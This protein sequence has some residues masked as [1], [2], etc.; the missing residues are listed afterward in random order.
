MKTKKRK[1][2][3]FISFF[4]CITLFLVGAFVFYN[5]KYPLKF[6]Q[7]INYYSNVFNL[8]PSLVASIINEESSF[9]CNCVS[10]SGAIGLM[11]IIPNTARY[12]AEEILKEEYIEEKLF[13][14]ETNIKYGCCYLNYLSKKFENTQEVLCAYNA[15][16]T[17]VN[18]WLNNKKYSENGKLL[19]KIPYSETNIYIN[20]ILKGKKYYMGRI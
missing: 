10:N 14:P 7:F 9:K 13:L 18:K 16:E 1:I 5:I 4:I 17:I 15:G 8:E 19:N 11:Q 2:F 3:Y 6:N 20:K 12:I